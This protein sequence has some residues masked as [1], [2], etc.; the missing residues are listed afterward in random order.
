MARFTGLGTPQ[1]GAIVRISAVKFSED[2]DY[3]NDDDVDEPQYEAGFSDTTVEE[4]EGMV[5]FH[6]KVPSCEASVPQ[7]GTAS[8]A[9][10]AFHDVAK[11]VNGD[12]GTPS[13]LNGGAGAGYISSAPEPR[14]VAPTEESGLLTPESL[15][16]LP[17]PPRTPPMPPRSERPSTPSTEPLGNRKYHGND[18]WTLNFDNDEMREILDEVLIHSSISLA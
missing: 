14:H 18:D 15:R 7:E 4:D 17:E 6:R 5:E 13:Q 9:T 8:T 1:A 2:E 11:Y 3:Q 10:N 12:C 16:Q